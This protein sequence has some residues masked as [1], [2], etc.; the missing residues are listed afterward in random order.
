MKLTHAIISCAIT[1]A[2]FVCVAA[3]MTD[4]TFGLFVTG[5]TFLVAAGIFATFWAEGAGTNG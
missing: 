2:A 1:G 4:I 5:G 3:Y